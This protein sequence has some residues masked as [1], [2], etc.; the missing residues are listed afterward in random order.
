M[1]SCDFFVLLLCDRSR[2]SDSAT[3]PSSTS[4]PDLMAVG[5]ALLWITASLGTF[6]V[7]ALLV[8]RFVLRT[9]TVITK[10]WPATK[11]TART[12]SGDAGTN[13]VH[14]EMFVEDSYFRHGVTIEGARGDDFFVLDCGANIGLFALAA[15][16]KC[17]QAGVNCEIH[18]FEPVPVLASLANENVRQLQNH[19]T[20][21]RKGDRAAHVTS[22]VHTVA[23]GQKAGGV[24]EFH[25]D[26][27]FSAGSTSHANELLKQTTRNGFPV[28]KWIKAAVHDGAWGGMVPPWVAENVI[29]AMNVP[30]LNWV[31][32][33][34]VIL[35]V[36]LLLLLFFSASPVKKTKVVAPLSSL[37]RELAEL[38]RT[39]RGGKPITRIDMVKIDVEG[40]EWDVMQ[41]L[42]P[43]RWRTVRQCVVEVHNGGNG[44]DG[45]R[46]NKVVAFLR[47]M[48]FSN[49]VVG[50]EELWS[51]ELLD[52]HT[53]FATRV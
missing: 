9:G 10:H 1:Q 14:R 3:I 39:T 43:D 29:R 15:G 25:Y 22:C 30:V 27:G 42:S 21:S 18:S 52:L 28:L 44:P 16:L 51:H 5:G 8:H 6:Y 53:V 13:L 50:E 7:A 33:V 11:V 41:G 38:E 20:G 31:I 49:V 37:D 2:P 34:L 36:G 24:A 4:P 26:P 12:V 32:A 35:P 40:A 19:R 17:L 48:G 45:Q 46:V 47:A 23:L